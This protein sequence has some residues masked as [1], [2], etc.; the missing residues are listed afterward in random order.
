MRIYQFS[1]SGIAILWPTDLENRHKISTSQPRMVTT[2]RLAAGKSVIIRCRKKDILLYKHYIPFRSELPK[3]VRPWCVL[4]IL[5]S[6]CACIAWCGYRMSKLCTPRPDGLLP[7]MINTSV[8]PGTLDTVLTDPLAPRGAQGSRISR[9]CRVWRAIVI[10]DR[11]DSMKENMN[12]SDLRY[13][14]IL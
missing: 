3:V 4:Y 12:P 13:P 10:D 8:L 7:S 11:L 5:T 1:I 6:K 2:W 9:G 14:E